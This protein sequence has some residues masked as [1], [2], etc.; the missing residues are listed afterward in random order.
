MTIQIVK[1]LGVDIVKLF[2]FSRLVFFTVCLTALCVN[3]LTSSY[4]RLLLYC[5]AVG[6]YTVSIQVPTFGGIL[7]ISLQKIA[8]EKI[9]TVYSNELAEGYTL[10]SV[11]I[12]MDK[13]WGS[14]IL[15]LVMF[16]EKNCH[17]REL[18]VLYIPV[19]SE[20]CEYF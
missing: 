10:M 2:D 19:K 16:V 3:A 9:Y 4:R 13:Y 8:Y 15:K 1:Y 20:Y 17:S 18:L 5:K 7:P 12:F 14:D 6:F 11:T